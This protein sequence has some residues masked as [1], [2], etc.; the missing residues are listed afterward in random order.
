MEGK[1][2]TCCMR[3]P[4]VGCTW[5][6]IRI[7]TDAKKEED[8]VKTRNEVPSGN[9][10]LSCG[11]MLLAILAMMA[12][13]AVEFYPASA[14]AA[15]FRAMQR[16]PEQIASRLKDRLNLTDDQVKA[17]EPIIR[18]NMAKRMELM[19]E[20]RQLREST[21]DKI[22]QILTKEQAVEFQKMRDRMRSRMERPSGRR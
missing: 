5:T 15:G 11:L 3:A 22:M 1:Y 4:A 20:M 18:D 7:N 9:K 17:I 6:G 2:Q 8:T 12:I 16:S 19:K 10:V 13:A 21:D 14:Q